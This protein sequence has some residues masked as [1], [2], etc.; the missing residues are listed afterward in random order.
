VPEYSVII[1]NYNHAA[2]LE[3]R[4]E[5]VLNQSYNDFEI[6][7]L[8]DHSTD[9]SRIIIEKFRRIEKIKH[10]V[11]NKKNSGSAFIQWMKGIKLARGNWIWIAESDDFA[12]STF[13]EKINRKNSSD[14]TG[15][16]F[17]R[18]NL[19]NE[20]GEAIILYSFSS[21]PDPGA[22]PVFAEDFSMDGNAFIGRYMLQM[23]SIP[24][25]SAVVFRKDLVDFSI[26][27]HIGKTKLFGD[28]LFWIH[29]LRKTSVSYIHEKLNYF[30]FHEGTV[31]R[32]TQFDLTRIYEYM[33]LIRYFEK[34]KMPFSKEALDAMLYQYYYGDVSM[35]RIS[36]KDRIKISMFVMK[37]NPSL[38]LKTWWRKRKYPK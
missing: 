23:N 20:K 22:C 28:W 7:I 18:S 12:D 13:L 36:L 1:P 24:N 27:D 33:F 21:M 37:R 29:L 31:R 16:V 9:E 32:H 6:I 2:F 30:R 3:K 38:L 4:I 8:D 35:N 11:F 19:I 5:S 17:C 26:F 10:I 15:L 25:A 34:E 14:K